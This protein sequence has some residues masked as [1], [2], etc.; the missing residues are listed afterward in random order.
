M[1]LLYVLYC[2]LA[3]PI[4]SSHL[5]LRFQNYCQC[6]KAVLPRPKGQYNVGGFRGLSLAARGHVQKS[7]P[8]FC[9]LMKSGDRGEK[10]V[11]KAPVPGASPEEWGRGLDNLVTACFQLSHKAAKPRKPLLA[12]ARHGR[13]GFF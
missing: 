9:S 11:L 6:F 2:W 12:A 4:Q 13:N 1:K 3:E 5:A 7:D 8:N 10:G